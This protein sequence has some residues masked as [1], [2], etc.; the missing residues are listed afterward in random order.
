MVDKSSKRTSVLKNE[1][2][3]IG[4]KESALNINHQELEK[5]ETKEELE[6]KRKSVLIQM[7]TSYLK[8]QDHNTSFENDRFDTDAF[9]PSHNRS[10]FTDLNN[11]KT[12]STSKGK[13]RKS[14]LKKIKRSQTILME[15]FKKKLHPGPNIELMKAEN[16]L[17][18]KTLN[19]LNARKKV[20]NKKANSVFKDNIF[21]SSQIVLNNMMNNRFLSLNNFNNLSF[22]EENVNVNNKNYFLLEKVKSVDNIGNEN[23]KTILINDTIY[24]LKKKESLE[25]SFPMELEI[26]Q[27]NK[28]NNC[29]VEIVE[30]FQIGSFSEIPS[31]TD[32]GIISIPDIQFNTKRRDGLI[33]RE[34]RSRINSNFNPDVNLLSM[35]KENNLSINW[36][37]MGKDKIHPKLTRHKTYD[38]SRHKSNISKKKSI[39]KAKENDRRLDF[40]I[41]FLANKFT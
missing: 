15:N 38:K 27:N 34:S 29:I 25:I 5:I 37:D 13:T 31:I 30:N 39:S 10:I 2:L 19:L 6:K 18:A 33:V 9:K 3:F 28:F 32:K 1:T 23:S 4:K 16:E 17:N 26:I 8:L 14:S 22:V 21:G 35:I 40:I 36:I 41:S 7:K 24:E 12:N 20:K 11:M